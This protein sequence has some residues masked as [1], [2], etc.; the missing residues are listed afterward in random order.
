MLEA[1]KLDSRPS[2]RYSRPKVVNLATDRTPHDGVTGGARL[3]AH[4]KVCP[5]PFARC[6]RGAS[7]NGGVGGA[8]SPS[9]SALREGGCRVW[10]LTLSGRLQ[11]V[12]LDASPT[13]GGGGPCH[14]HPRGERGRLSSCVG[15]PPAR[16]GG[17]RA[18]DVSRGGRACRPVS[19][20][21]RV[22][23]CLCRGEQEARPTIHGNQSQAKAQ[24]D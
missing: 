13:C 23:L 1:S 18:W 11:G 21:N 8:L 5:A 7:C 10:H 22:T 17:F 3:C 2:I 15:R 9:C 20:L 4:D 12:A 14:R 6:G 16:R 19:L 24:R